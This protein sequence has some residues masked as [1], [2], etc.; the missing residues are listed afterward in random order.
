MRNKG[1]HKKTETWT[2]LMDWKDQLHKIPIITK[3]L[4]ILYT[5]DIFKQM[6]QKHNGI[7]LKQ[8]SI[9]KR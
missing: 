9:Q 1:E 5:H 6:N 2:L 3:A 8:I 4:Y 7:H